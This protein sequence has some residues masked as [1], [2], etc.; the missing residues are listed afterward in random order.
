MTETKLPHFFLKPTRGFACQCLICKK[1]KD[2]KT[3]KEA[4]KY[5]C[6]CKDEKRRDKFLSSKELYLI[7]ENIRRKNSLEFVLTE[8]KHK[9]ASHV[10]LT[11]KKQEELLEFKKK[12]YECQG[13]K[14]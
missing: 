10:Q 12:F 6:P 13:V 1:T 9:S 4:E 8:E 11:F 3:E 7:G 5:K 14:P 2:F